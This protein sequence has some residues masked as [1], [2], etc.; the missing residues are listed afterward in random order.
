MADGFRAGGVAVDPLAPV[1]EGVPLD[2]HFV[3]SGATGGA[4]LN[5]L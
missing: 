2:T 5:G 4:G 3:L 1:A